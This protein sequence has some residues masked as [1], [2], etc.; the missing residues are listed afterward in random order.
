M[1]TSECA[2]EDLSKSLTEGQGKILKLILGDWIN[3]AKVCNLGNYNIAV[4]SDE[5]NNSFFIWNEKGPLLYFQNGFGLN[6]F[7]Q[8]TNNDVSNVLLTLQDRNKNGEF[9]RLSYQT[10]NN[11]DEVTDLDMDGQPD[12]KIRHKK[13]KAQ[14]YFNNEWYELDLRDKQQGIIKNGEFHPVEFEKGKWVLK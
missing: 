7:R 1:A 5:K 11:K 10:L 3:S 13:E 12:L 2:I 4:P 6:L 9:D 8:D 14:I